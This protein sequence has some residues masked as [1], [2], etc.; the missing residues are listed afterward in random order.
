MLSFAVL[1]SAILRLYDDDE[2]FPQL[3]DSGDVD[4]QRSWTV[5]DRGLLLVVT[6]LSPVS[7]PPRSTL[8]LYKVI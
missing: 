5:R 4:C 1:C 3:C 6:Q 2:L 8:D 7:V